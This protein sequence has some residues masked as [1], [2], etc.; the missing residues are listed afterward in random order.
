M[1][2]GHTKVTAEAG[3]AAA[4]DILIY[5]SHFELDMLM[6]MCG[7]RPPGKKTRFALFAISKEF[8]S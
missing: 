8:E 7:L 1:I 6:S 2:E 5:R 4:D 3:S